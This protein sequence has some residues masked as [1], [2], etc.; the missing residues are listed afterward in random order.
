MR[1]RSQIALLVFG[2]LVP[3]V[4]F[5]FTA[6]RQLAERE[7][8]SVERNVMARVRAAMSAVDVHVQGSIATLDALATSKNLELGDIAAFHAETQR[9]LRSQPS[10]VNIGLTSA[11]KMQLSNAVYAFS[12]PWP[13]GMQ[14]ESFEA[15]VRSGKPAIGSVAAGDVVRSPTVRVRVPVIQNGEVRYVLSAP[16]SLKY[17]VGVL[18]AQRLPEDWVVVLFDREKRIIARIPHLPA[19][20]PAADSFKE[21]TARAEVWFQGTTEGRANYT[22][23]VTSP[24]TGWGLGVEMP[25]AEIDAGERR[26]FALVG[27]VLLVAFV[28]GSLLGWLIARRRYLAPPRA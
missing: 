21:Q 17:L 8:E 14:D 28:A 16:Q 24:L 11:A 1:L 2:A 10:W 7:R 26:I 20:L 27:A 22:A 3:T 5:T 18:E 15:V 13:L 6:A 25:A 9:V 4:V 19:G 23:Y 12:K